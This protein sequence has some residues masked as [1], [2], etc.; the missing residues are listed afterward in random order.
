M[1]LYYS[2]G[3]CSQS[4]HIVAH[5]LGIELELVKVNTHTHQ[6]ADG[7]DF[8]TINP[9]GYVPVLELDDGARL[10]EGPAIVQYLADLKP[11]AGLAPRNG[12]F[13]RYRLQET[14]G[15]INS[16][17]HKGFSPLFDKSLPADVIAGFRNKLGQRLDILAQQLEGRD[18]LMGERFTVA[19]AY[20]FVVLGWAGYVDLDLDAWPALKAFRQRV[21]QRPAVREALKAESGRH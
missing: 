21:A 10:T 16:E 15:F 11:E 8:Y 12:T 7:T 4:P 9:K 20:L 3:L 19:D 17:V 2:P 1:K 6:L 18:Y 5:E 14:L 13:E